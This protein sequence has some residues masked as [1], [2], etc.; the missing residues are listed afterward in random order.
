MKLAYLPAVAALVVWELAAAHPTAAAPVEESGRQF[1][2]SV[3][4]TD[5][6]TTWTLHATGKATRKKFVVKVYAMVH[7]MDVA[8]FPTRDDALTAVRDGTHVRRIEME[9]VRGV[10]ANKIANAYREGFAAHTTAAER[11]AIQPL[12]DQFVGY[13]NADVADGDRYE[14]TA[15]PGGRVTVTVQGNEKPAIT[16]KTFARSLWAI[17]F[18]KN[19]VVQSKDLVKFT[20]KAKRRHG[21]RSR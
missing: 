14:Y 7:Y 17:W 15:F 8:T 1:P 13:H 6:T 21:R 2:D 11:T 20:A 12:I 9:F 18:G 19:S 10:G 3:T 4:V 5:G 16:N